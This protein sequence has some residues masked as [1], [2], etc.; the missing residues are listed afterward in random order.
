LDVNEIE[1]LKKFIL[2]IKT[3][4]IE[5]ARKPFNSF[6]LND[7][8]L[9]S[10]FRNILSSSKFHFIYSNGAN[11]KDGIFEISGEYNPSNFYSLFTEKQLKENEESSFYK[12]I[13][14]ECM[15]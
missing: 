10:E 6:F 12:F 13:Y 11:K 2:N 7:G 4:I 14:D 9:T 8:S 5:Y 3:R 15:Y 1:E